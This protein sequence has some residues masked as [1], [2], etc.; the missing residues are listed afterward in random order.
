M[1]L[2][3]V[4]YNHILFV[5]SGP[6]LLGSIAHTVAVTDAA[7]LPGLL[8]LSLLSEGRREKTRCPMS[9]VVTGCLSYIYVVSNHIYRS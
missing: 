9:E 7:P 8:L 3:T 2:V 1:L 6:R 4:N 5:L